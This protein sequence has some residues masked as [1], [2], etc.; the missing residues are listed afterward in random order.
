MSDSTLDSIN[1][2]RGVPAG[3]LGDYIS[4]VRDNWG[5]FALLGALLLVGGFYALGAVAFSSVA[6]TVYV[7]V[8]MIIA[9]LFHVILGFRAKSWGRLFWMLFLGVLYIAAG[10]SVFS[11]PAA[12]TAIL[13]LVL[14]ATFLVMGGLR[15]F[16]AFGLPSDVTRWPF[17]LSAIATLVL[18]MMIVMGWPQSSAF[19]LG[20]LLGIEMIFS[21]ASWLG[22]AFAVRKARVA[23]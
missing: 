14:G 22:F 13:T 20:T 12:A 3:R 11:N 6:V 9:G 19:T 10:A 18:G 2:P 7:G 4:S 1:S 21:G 15:L 17:F 16:M 8:L 5:W 23:N